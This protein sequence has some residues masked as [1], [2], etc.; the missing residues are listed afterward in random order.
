MH[1]DATTAT[2][3]ELLGAGD[4][5]LT[6][7]GS[8][9]V[10]TLD[11]AQSISDLADS[12]NALDLGVSANVVMT[13]TDEYRLV[14]TS[15]DTGEDAAFAMT[16]TVTGFTA[17]TTSVTAT[18]AVIQIG[19]GVTALTIER[20]TNSFSDVIDGVTFELHAVA[21]DVTVSTARDFNGSGDG[22]ADVVAKLNSV[23]S[24]IQRLTSYDA[25]TGTSGILAGDSTARALATS[26]RAAVSGAVGEGA[27]PYVGAAIGVS[28]TRTGTFTF[29]QATFEEALS[30]DFEG[31]TA[32]LDDVVLDNLDTELDAIEGSGGSIARARDRWQNQIDFMNDRITAF[33]DRLDRREAALIRQFSALEVSLQN[34]YSQSQ[35]LTNQISGLNGAS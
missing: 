32:F 5:T 3:D 21:D 31:V 13:D 2:A 33:E 6:V 34:L 23:L 15:D 10:I 7:D 18:D 14:L 26:L 27:S 24:E 29:D 16:S 4:L 12:V 35:W 8:D 1:S 20:P 11:G 9:H 28:L 30:N 22:V 19:S 17:F 25:T